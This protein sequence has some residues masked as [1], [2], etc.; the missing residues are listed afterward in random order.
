LSG[1]GRPYYDADQQAVCIDVRSKDTQ[2]LMVQAGSLFDLHEFQEAVAVYTDIIQ[3]DPQHAEAYHRR[4]ACHYNMGDLDK[5]LADFNRAI[6]LAPQNAETY[7]HRALVFLRQKQYEKGL[8]DAKEGLRLDPA[9]PKSYTSVM[10]MAYS[11]RAADHNNQHHPKE[12]LADL[13]ELVQLEPRNAGV[14]QR[15][16]IVYYNLQDFDHAIADLTQAIEIA[17][18][19]NSYLYRSYAHRAKGE[20]EKAEADLKRARAVGEQGK[21]KGNRKA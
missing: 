15:R 6:A 8:A 14:F 21:E 9:D 12:A 1:P 2:Q 5:A 11:A 7:K 4:G 19:S 3:E 10:A 16:G 18:D 20:V 17:P 13:N